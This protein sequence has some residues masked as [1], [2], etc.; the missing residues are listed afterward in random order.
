MC[1]LDTAANWSSWS[2]RCPT[3]VRDESL[4]VRDRR[5]RSVYD[6]LDLALSHLAACQ[7]GRGVIAVDPGRAAERQLRHST[8]RNRHEFKCAHVASWPDQRTLTRQGFG[9]GQGQ[10]GLRA[11]ESRY[12]QV[13]A[14]QER[15]GTG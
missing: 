11:Q 3:R 1:I 13:Y 14:I 2:S 5:G 9:E 6:S 10:K 12:R 8:G 4:G 15:D 7:H